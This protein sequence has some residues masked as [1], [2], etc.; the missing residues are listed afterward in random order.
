MKTLEVEIINA[1][2]QLGDEPRFVSALTAFERG[3]YTHVLAIA[4]GNLGWVTWLLGYTPTELLDGPALVQHQ[5][6]T[7]MEGTLRNG[8][9]E[10]LW[11]EYHA[12]GTR[13]SEGRYENDL[14]QGFWREWHP[15]GQLAWAGWYKDG[16]P[17]SVWAEWDK[18]GN[19]IHR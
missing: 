7:L 5:S 14:R 15:N 11:H 4:R 8:K 1:I 16:I 13:A 10:G 19:L 18:S 3:D 17:T 9:R 6:R 12:D 2:R